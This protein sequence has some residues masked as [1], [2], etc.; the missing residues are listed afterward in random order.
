MAQ[1]TLSDLDFILQQ[2]RYA[3]AHATGTT[4]PQALL[5]NSLVPWGLR[6]LDGTFTNLGDGGLINSGPPEQ[7]SESSPPVPPPNSPAAA[8]A[9]VS[10]LISDQHEPIPNT[11]PDA[12]LSAPFNSLMTYFAQ[13]VGH[14]L[15]KVAVDENGTPSTPPPPSPTSARS[16]APTRP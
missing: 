16:T 4:D 2:I 14:D 15:V 11:A 3:E 5:P 12:G 10:D 13:F 7:T 1:F 6:T 8:P 9:D